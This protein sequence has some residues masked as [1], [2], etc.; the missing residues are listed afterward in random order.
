MIPEVETEIRDIIS[1]PR[2]QFAIMQDRRAWYQLCAALD[3]LGDTQLAIDS[4]P[5]IASQSDGELYLIIYGLLQAMFLQQDAVAHLAEAVNIPVTDHAGLKAVRDIRNDVVG[6]PTKRGGNNTFTTHTISRWSLSK[7]VFEVYSSDKDAKSFRQR[8]I[9]IDELIENQ[10]AGIEKQVAA[11]R[12][13]LLPRER[14]GATRNNQSLEDVARFV[15]PYVRGWVNYYG[16]FYQSALAPILRSLERSLTYW[17]RR[18]YKR[19]RGHKRHAVHWLG[20]ISRREPKLFVH[21]QI[22]IRPAAG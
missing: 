19:L 18:K 16:R 13:E 15:N 1:S 4:F 6:H 12:D 22:G 2:R 10:R 17:A 14:L 9:A 8:A 7:V 11:V 21:W 5:S 3:V 20:S